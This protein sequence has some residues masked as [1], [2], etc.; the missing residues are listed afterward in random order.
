MS[1]R[2]ASGGQSIGVSASTTV[3]LVNTQDW[4]PLISD[5]KN[6]SGKREKGVSV[7]TAVGGFCIRLNL[8][9]P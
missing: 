3:L 6:V 5:L 7:E 9:S 2:S 4:S 8:D 1:Q